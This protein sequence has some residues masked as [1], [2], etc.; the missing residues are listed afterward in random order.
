MSME[1]PKELLEARPKI[2]NLSAME[3]KRGIRDCSKVITTHCTHFLDIQSWR[4]RHL[5]VDNSR[6][7]TV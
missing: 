1:T 6:Y 2:V 5:W 7:T 3:Y 4:D